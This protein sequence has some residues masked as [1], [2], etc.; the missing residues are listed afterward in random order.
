MATLLHFLRPFAVTFLAGFSLSLFVLGS[1][2]S[3]LM[4]LAISPVS[5]IFNPAYVQL[6]RFLIAFGAGDR[7]EGLFV[8]ALTLGLVASLLN[9][10]TTYKRSQRSA[11][12]LAAN[13]ALQ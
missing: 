5:L 7:L 8:I 13:E 9:G 11:W 6:S 10:F 2:F 12:H 4:V 1:A 3:G